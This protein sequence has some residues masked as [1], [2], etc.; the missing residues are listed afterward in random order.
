ME[1]SD[2]APDWAKIT[3]GGTP[4]QARAVLGGLLRV[5]DPGVARTRPR[6]P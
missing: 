1:S 5:F 4:E 6:L 3:P 2:V